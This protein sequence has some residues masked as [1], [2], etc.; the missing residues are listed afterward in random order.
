[1]A[2]NSAEMARP[3]IEEPGLPRILA[4][5]VTHDGRKWLTESLVGLA[6]QTYPHLDVLV[7]DD[8]SAVE[9]GASALKRVAKRHLRR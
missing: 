9:P 2:T 3:D 5:L 1:M 8:A 7:V 4:I 6:G